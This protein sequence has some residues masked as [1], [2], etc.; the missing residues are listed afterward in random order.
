[1]Q[2]RI[3][4]LLFIGLLLG[5][6]SENVFVDDTPGQVLMLKVDYT[7]NRFEGGT[8]FHFS[9]STDDFTIENEYKEPG[10]FGNVK[11]RYKE[12]NEPLFEGTIHWMGLGEMLFPEKLEPARNFD[13]L[14]TEDIVYPVNGF[15]DVF[16]PLNLDLEYDAAWFAVQNLVKARE[17]LRANPAQKVK[18][19]LYTPSVGE[20]NP[21]DWDWIIY[22]KR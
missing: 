19:F 21:E 8:E 4:F 14:V 20:G 18:L 17:Y 15:E 12:L 13:R 10:D 11:L 3:L 2:V 16:N 22:L 7:T 6:N 9:R 5:C 1:M